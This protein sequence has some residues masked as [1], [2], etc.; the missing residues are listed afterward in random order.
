MESAQ[1]E[2]CLNDIISDLYYGLIEVAEKTR[3]GASREE[4]ADS[5]EGLGRIVCDH[6]PDCFAAIS[7]SPSQNSQKSED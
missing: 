7:T 1:I 2:Q 3:S 6:W 5:I 4:I